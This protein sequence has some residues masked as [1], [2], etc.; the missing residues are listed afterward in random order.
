MPALPAEPP[1]L[2]LGIAA[3]PRWATLFAALGAGAL[4]A[5]A[6]QPVGTIAG[7]VLGVGLL[8]ILLVQAPASRA[9][10]LGLL[11]GFGNF[12]LGLTWIATAFTYQANMPVWMGWVA[13]VG[14][15]L[16]LA[17]YTGFAAW[18]ARRLTDRIV[19]LARLF[20]LLPLCL[21]RC[22]KTDRKSSK[23]GFVPTFSLLR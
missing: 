4:S 22:F 17:L 9:F 12:A 11:F 3:L 6:F 15:S 5:L 1:R 8:L 20:V 14:L 2:I 10:A 13:V 18:A 21:P 19:P 16:F 23:N 7:P